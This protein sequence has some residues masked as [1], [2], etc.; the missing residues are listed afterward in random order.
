MVRRSRRLKVQDGYVT[1]HWHLLTRSHFRCQEN[2]VLLMSGNLISP[3]HMG[4][5]YTC[6]V[7]VPAAA[8]RRPPGPAPVPERSDASVRRAP[9]SL[10]LRVTVGGRT[11]PRPSRRTQILRG[12]GHWRDVSGPARAARD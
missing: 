4:K 9:D 12:S 6:G 5:R 8:V 11:E 2:L 7:V 1:W 10:R 3:L